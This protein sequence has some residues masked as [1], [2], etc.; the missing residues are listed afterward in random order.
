M[1]DE[2]AEATRG[3]Q[4]YDPLMDM[5][6]KTYEGFPNATPEPAYESTYAQC[7]DSMKG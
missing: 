1:Q 4:M 5:V 7:M 6:F 2:I 3:T